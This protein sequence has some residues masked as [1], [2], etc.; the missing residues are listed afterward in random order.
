MKLHGLFDHGQLW[1][2]RLYDQISFTPFWKGD[3]AFEELQLFRRPLSSKNQLY[4]RFWNLQT[5]FRNL[6]S[7]YFSKST[8]GKFKIKDFKTASTLLIKVKTLDLKHH[9][10]TK[11]IPFSYPTKKLE[12]VIEKDICP[13]FK[14]FESLVLHG[15]KPFQ[16]LKE[17]CNDSKWYS[18]VSLCWNILRQVCKDSF[19]F[20]FSLICAIDKRVISYQENE[21]LC[22]HTKAIVWSSSQVTKLTRKGRNNAKCNIFVKSLWKASNRIEPSE[23]WFKY[24]YLGQMSH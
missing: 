21:S 9:F 7:S 6:L 4:S 1:V 19:T 14:G 8:R 5:S 24:L 13:I 10:R 15:N 16:L 22:L 11:K 18:N 20:L 23:M 12:T 3:P 17:A 2:S